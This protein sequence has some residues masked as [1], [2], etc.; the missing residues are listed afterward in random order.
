MTDIA[1]DSM[2][3]KILSKSVRIETVPWTSE[4]KFRPGMIDW[5]S[6]DAGGL[7]GP[8]VTEI[9]II[10]YEQCETIEPAKKE[11]STH[12][13]KVH[14]FGRI[15][16]IT[17]DIDDLAYVGS[18]TGTIEKR[19]AE[20]KNDALNDAQYL[21]H[22]HMRAYGIEHFNIK[23]LEEITQTTLNTLHALET[24]HIVRQ[25]TVFNGLNMTYPRNTCIHNSRVT[26]CKLC[27]AHLFCEH[28]KYIRSCNECKG[29]PAALLIC[30][31]Q[32]TRSSCRYCNNCK[33]CNSLNTP[34]HINSMVHKQNE[35][36]AIEQESRLLAAADQ[37]H[38]ADE[39]YTH[40][41]FTRTRQ[42]LLIKCREKRSGLVHL[43]K[44]NRAK[45]IMPRTKQEEFK[46]AWEVMQELLNT[47]DK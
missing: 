9:R 16:K 24:I 37:K 15:Y 47:A 31:H 40:I 7:Y 34:H 43:Q 6:M 23:L 38:K 4:S 45:V 44:L 35:I 5:F 30:R 41:G 29:T 13:Q 33:Y 46:D 22:C 21:L 20:H 10:Q 42:A 2:S 32:R 19:F 3:L 36:E 17:N 14:A 28:T 8:D 11:S 12:E 1:N 39:S 25:K 26:K 27:N 18:T